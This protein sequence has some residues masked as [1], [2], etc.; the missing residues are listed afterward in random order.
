MSGAIHRIQMS[1][2]DVTGAQKVVERLARR[3]QTI[4]EADFHAT[5]E[6]LAHE[7]P[8]SLRAGLVDFRLREPAAVCVISGWPVDDDRVGPTPTDWREQ[9]LPSPTLAED[10]FFYLC[11]T[12]LGE[13]FSW[14]TAQRGRVIQ[15]ILPMRRNKNKQLG[16][17]SETALT[18][19]IEDSFH[20]LR[21]DY[22]GL[23]CV[24]N[25]DGV[26]T[27]CAAVEDVEIPVE[28]QQALRAAQ[29]IIRPDESH[30][31]ETLKAVAIE[32]DV[33]AELLERSLAQHRDLV[34][35]PNEISVLFGDPEQ[36]YL[37]INSFYM[38]TPQNE[39]AQ[40]ALAGVIELLDDAMWGVALEPGDVLFLDNYRAVHGRA[41]FIAR[42]DGTDRWLR[43]LNVARDLRRSRCLRSS[44][45]ARIVF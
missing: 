43:R 34:D 16:T 8:H 2:E 44:A 12:M 6:V 33:S 39:A 26:L 10:I 23:F 30:S 7:L 37:L 27:T 25:P 1:D 21:A 36:P 45:E 13:P 40:A 42:F 32:R 3:H 5:A 20:P 15:D 22:V 9:S 18:W 19:H 28:W 17:S 31:E 29:F 11:A 4:E 41:P 14:A 35:N 24:R 38:D